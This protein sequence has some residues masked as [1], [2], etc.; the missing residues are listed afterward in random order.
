MLMTISLFQVQQL[1]APKPEPVKTTP[2]PH[3]S[4]ATPTGN[5]LPIHPI[6]QTTPTGGNAMP[7][8]PLLTQQN[9]KVQDSLPSRADISPESHDGETG[10]DGWR[11]PASGLSWL[12][13][14]YLGKPLDKS[15]Q[16]SNWE[17][18]PL[19]HQQIKYAG[20]VCHASKLTMPHL[21]TH[22]AT[23]HTSMPPLLSYHVTL[24]C[25]TGCSLSVG[26]VQTPGI[27]SSG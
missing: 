23:P 27:S 3:P 4:P 11:K 15:Q 17:R 14:R 25:S 20:T 13:E 1:L 7:V 19:H 26:C 18:R 9:C 21:Q 5:V 22:Y 2:K 24:I 16:L 8:H 6:Y 10:V 12:V